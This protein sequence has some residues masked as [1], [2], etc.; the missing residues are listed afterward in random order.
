MVV[1]LGSHKVDIANPSL[2]DSRNLNFN[3]RVK[4]KGVFKLSNSYLALK[5]KTA[6]KMRWLATLL[7]STVQALFFGYLS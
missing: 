1:V 6:F 7:S 3:K 5:A 2:C 4:N